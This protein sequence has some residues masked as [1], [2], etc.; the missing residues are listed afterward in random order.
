MK[1]N[2]GLSLLALLALCTPSCV[3]SNIRAPLDTDL[4]TTKLG[5]K[6]GKA[7]AYSVLWL[8]A[9]GEAGAADAAKEGKITTLNHMD[10]ETFIILGGL[11]SKTTTIVYGE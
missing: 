5:Y 9:W 3:Y 4:S 8:V 7:S 6:V 2:L 11:Y 10:L 1:K